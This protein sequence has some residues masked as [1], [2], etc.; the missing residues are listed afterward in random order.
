MK[1]NKNYAKSGIPVVE[2]RVG[3]LRKI[4][5]FNFAIVVP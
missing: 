5:I 2:W 3:C 4:F 1:N